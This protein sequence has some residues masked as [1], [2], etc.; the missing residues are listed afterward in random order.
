MG[1]VKRKER[2]FSRTDAS[3]CKKLTKL[4]GCAATSSSHVV[5]DVGQSTEPPRKSVEQQVEVEPD[6]H[7]QTDNRGT[8]KWQ[9]HK[10]VGCICSGCH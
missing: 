5:L 9:G 3:K 2:Q 1:K 8:G 6:E 10:T 7:P 4:S